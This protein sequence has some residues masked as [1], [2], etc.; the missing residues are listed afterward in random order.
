MRVR[1]PGGV[2]LRTRRARGFSHHKPTT[3]LIGEDDLEG[4]NGSHSAMVQ[5][6]KKNVVGTD[7]PHED[8]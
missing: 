6:I 5:C 4:V 8:V 1:R 7:A 3:T 2:G